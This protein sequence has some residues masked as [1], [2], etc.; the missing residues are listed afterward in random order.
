M[1]LLDFALF[2]QQLAQRSESGELVYATDNITAYDCM[3]ASEE[4]LARDWNTPEEDKAW[5][6]L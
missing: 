3:L 2:L 6:N 4:V 5:T 1:E